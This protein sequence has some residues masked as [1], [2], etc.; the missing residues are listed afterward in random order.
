MGL[1][2]R[3][4]GLAGGIGL[5]LGLG[6]VV[7]ALLYLGWLP[8]GLGTSAGAWLTRLMSRALR[9]G[10]VGGNVLLGALN[11]LLPCGLVYG[12]LLA[13]ASLGG[14]LPAAT[15]MIVFGV[16]TMPALAVVGLGAGSLG[17]PVRQNMARLAGLLMIGLGFQQS[18]RG[19]A[20]LGLATHLH[21]GDVMLW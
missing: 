11:G 18:L 3:L 4:N 7:S 13:V 8:L 9:L 1:G 6:V 14:P 12:A 19:L 20:A 17:A 5:L 15:G 2:G 10:G 16:A 21:W